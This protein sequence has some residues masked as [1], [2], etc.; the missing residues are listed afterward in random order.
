MAT[1]TIRNVSDDL[2]QRLKNVA[3]SKGRS[4]EQEVRKLL[5]GRYANRSQI[6]AR[7]RKRWE[8]LPNATPDEIKR[9]KEE[10]RP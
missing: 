1:L 2:V 10:G 6:L 5:Q 9:W 8:K 7:A 3:Q 4:I